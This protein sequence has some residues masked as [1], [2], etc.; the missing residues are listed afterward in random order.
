ISGNTVLCN[1]VLGNTV[2]GNTVLDNVMRGNSVHDITMRGNSVHDITMRGNSVHDITVRGR[3]G[4]CPS[5]SARRAPKPNQPKKET[6]TMKRLFTS[7]L[8]ILLITIPTLPT[9]GAEQPITPSG[10]TQTQMEQQIET[11]ISEHIGTS[12][13]GAALAI[14]HQGEIIF[15]RGWGYANTTTQTP[16]NPATTIFEHASIAKLFTW[17]AAKQLSEQGLLNLD[18]PITNYL[19]GAFIFDHPFTM[20]NLMNHSGGFA[21][22]IID[23]Y[24]LT[25][26]YLPTQEDFLLS[27]Q[28]PQIFIPGTVS[29]YSNWGT[30]LA[31]LALANASG[32]PLANLLTQNIFEPANMHNTLIATHH[33]DNQALQANRVQGYATTSNSFNPLPSAYVINYGSGG[34][35]GTVEDLARFIIALTPADG[36][37]SPLFTNTQTL[38][39]LLSPSSLNHDTRPGTH[40]GFQ[41]FSLA[42]PTFGH[43]GSMPTTSTFLGFTPETRFGFAIMANSGN[44]GDL[45]TDTMRLLLGTPQTVTPTAN[46]NLPSTEGLAGRYLTAR[47]FHGN[48]LEAAAY[49]GAAGMPIITITPLDD[50]RINLAFGGGRGANVVYIQTAPY[51]FHVYDAG[52]YQWLANSLPSVQFHAEDGTATKILLPAGDMI[53]LEGMRTMPFLVTYSVITIASVAFF[54]LAPLVLL[55]VY[56]I[57]RKKGASPTHFDLFTTGL[58]LSGTALVANNLMMLLRMM[59]SFTRMA[60]ELQPH[61]LLN[62]VFA[63]TTALMLAGAIWKWNTKPKGK[64][65]FI[66][67]AIISTMLII[68]LQNWN[69]FTFL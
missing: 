3:G 49:I 1:N 16:I 61:I 59:S 15:S 12:T 29:A 40:H 66:T 17:T 10:L 38:Q 54:I 28:P 37:P 7:L 68:T 32:M 35:N 21:D 2:L 27:T 48:F 58:I 34:T 57:K 63:I 4:H 36:Q 43:G 13:P 60:S 41:H 52:D 69:F 51:T 6:K 20:R 5:Q 53:A 47:R 30:G 11:L 9:L 14:T 42:P 23:M 31:G 62:W 26:D 55:V 45:L 18:A 19:P 65:L 64:T 44:V 22:V 33:F 67:T 24:P 25:L 39:A 8:L 56:L 46:I 50:N